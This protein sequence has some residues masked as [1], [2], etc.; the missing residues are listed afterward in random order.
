MPLRMSSSWLATLAVAALALTVAHAQ[1]PARQFTL[2]R[3]YLGAGMEI[4]YWEFGGHSV[5]SDEYIRLTPDRQS[6]QGYLW[7]RLPVLFDHWDLIVEF[8]VHGSG[9][10]L[11][12][13]GMAFWYAKQ[14][15]TPGPVFGSVDFFSGLGLFFD[16]Y[17]NH[18]GHHHHAHPYISAMIGDG[19]LHYDH[20]ADGTLTE[21]AG[22]EAQF[23]NKP[24]PTRFRVTYLNNVLQVFHDID[25]ERS[26]KECFTKSGVHLPS[27][28]HLG[29]SAAT[30]DVADAH[31]V[32][33]AQ[34]TQLHGQPKQ[35][36]RP[37]QE[38]RELRQTE[39]PFVAEAPLKRERVNDDHGDT[40]GSTLG[41]IALIFLG[42]LAVIALI[43]GGIVFYRSKQEQHKAKRLY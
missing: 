22:C 15:M 32:I 40:I 3:P 8:K 31:D 1:E 39:V 35:P 26:W 13:D 2:S 17:S 18:N 27:G 28:Y 38:T 30:G 20:D 21:L 14:P 5:V 4:P 42:S 34:L 36:Q 25:N 33:T 23:R 19:T 6:K 7:S 9:R 12:G 10:K 24:Y 11:F 29:F 37:L 43:V 16:T 41:S